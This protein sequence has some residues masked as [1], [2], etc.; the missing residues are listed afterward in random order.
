V[1]FA[2][3]A[4]GESVFV[5]ANVLVYR[6]SLHPQFAPACRQLLERVDRRDIFGYTSAHVLNEA[7]YRLLTLEA[8]TQFGWPQSGVNRRMRRHPAEVKKLIRFRRAI[9]RIIQSQLQLVDITAQLVLR[10]TTISQQLGLLS[11]DALIVAVMQQHGLQ[12]SPAAIRISMGSRASRGLGPCK[13]RAGRA[14]PRRSAEL[15]QNPQP[16]RRFRV[17][18]QVRREPVPVLKR[19]LPCRA[20]AGRPCPPI[21]LRRLR[22]TR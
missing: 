2:D 11:N 5:D 19:V 7:A 9:E 17:I 3:I 15:T 13:P 20:S 16:H 8:I 18:R 6:F 10:G 1:T 21:R 14:A 4:S 22:T 12:T